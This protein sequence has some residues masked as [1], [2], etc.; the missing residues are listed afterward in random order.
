MI[1]LI[2]RLSVKQAHDYY[3]IAKRDKAISVN[4]HGY[5]ASVL[6]KKFTWHFSD[7]FSEPCSMIVIQSAHFKS[8]F[9]V[10]K[11]VS[12]FRDFNY[13][14]NGMYAWLD[15]DMAVYMYM[16]AMK[17]MAACTCNTSNLTTSKN[18]PYSGLYLHLSVYCSSM[19]MNCLLDLYCTYVHT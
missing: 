7:E 11:R 8:L 1:G 13:V 19:I 3:T 2:N 4:V 17:Y 14:I 5:E 16:K 12:Y 6:K 9:H 10:Y 15:E 18:L